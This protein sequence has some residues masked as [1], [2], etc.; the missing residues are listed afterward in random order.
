MEWIIGLVVV[1]IVVY[2]IS[3]S[4]SG[5]RSDPPARDPRNDTPSDE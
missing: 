5:N 3:R 2:A 1:A 4:R